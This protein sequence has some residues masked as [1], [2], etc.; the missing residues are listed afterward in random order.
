VAP[1]TAPAV[2]KLHDADDVERAWRSDVLRGTP[3][4]S[5]AAKFDTVEINL[6]ARKARDP[7]GVERCAD[8]LDVWILH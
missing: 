4:P 6:R 8:R 5:G 1:L 7:R 2:A 3:Q